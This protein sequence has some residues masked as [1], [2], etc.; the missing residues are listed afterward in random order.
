[1]WSTSGN[2]RNA[3]STVVS[4]KHQLIFSA[5]L[6]IKKAMN[7]YYGWPTVMWME[8]ILWHWGYLVQ[9]TK[10]KPYNSPIR[11]LFIMLSYSKCLCK[12]ESM[13][14]L[15]FHHGISFSSK[16]R[17]PR[18]KAVVKKLNSNEVWAPGHYP[19]LLCIEL[20]A[21]SHMKNERSK[22]RQQCVCT[23]HWRNWWEK[24]W[25]SIRSIWLVP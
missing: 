10:L 6:Y 23:G 20:F 2:I 11:Q 13:F 19:A 12:A 7:K 5:G 8:G 4:Y 24:K 15:P 1:M 9:D 3:K 18:K 22:N 25:K 14:I 16:L 17:A 21:A